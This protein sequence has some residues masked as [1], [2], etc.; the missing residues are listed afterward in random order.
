MF[1]CVNGTCFQFIVAIITHKFAL[2]VIK[3]KLLTRGVFNS[4]FF[5][6]DVFICMILKD[7]LQS[8]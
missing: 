5:L 3:M 7:L 4:F 8:S 6:R 1:S 2:F